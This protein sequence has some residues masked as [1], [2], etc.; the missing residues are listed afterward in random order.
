MTLVVDEEPV[1]IAPYAAH[2][3]F[4]D[5]IRSGRSDRCLD[6]PGAERSE[7]A[8][9]GPGELRVAIPDALARSPPARFDELVD[10]PRQP[11]VLAYG[12]HRPGYAIARWT[13]S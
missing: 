4:R 1:G 9:E 12:D 13:G 5:H 3:P 11:V 8:I 7:N 2:I 10:R 6:H